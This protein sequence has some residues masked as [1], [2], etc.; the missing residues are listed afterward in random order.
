MNRTTRRVA[1][2]AL[3]SF[4]LAACAAEQA[5]MTFGGMTDSRPHPGVKAA[6]K[7]PVHGIDVSRWQGDI[8]WR[9]VRR[10][11]ATFAFIKAT[12]GGDHVD[13]KFLQNWYGARDAGVWRGAYHF[14]YWCRP[15]EEQVQWFIQHIPQD[16]DALPPVLDVEWNGHSRTCPRRVPREQA[17]RM[18][19]VMLHALEQHTGKRPIIY[20]DI[21]FY[22]D[23]LQDG[24][25]EQYPL[26]IR[27]TAA[28]PHMRYDRRWYFWQYTT[29]GRVPGIKGPVDRNAFFGTA[30]MWDK[31]TKGNL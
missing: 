5:H 27:S 13:P 11:G 12:E 14:V 19:E 21:P 20:T 31:F 29:T 16:P 2:A 18:M 9:A 3:L 22:R 17:L 15:A 4:A 10:A 26:W 23:V 25:F 28:E 7:L 8:D 6:L 1:A 24:G 30:D